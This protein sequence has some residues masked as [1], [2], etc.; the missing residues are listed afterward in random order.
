MKN[1]RLDG[2]HLDGGGLVVAVVC[3]GCFIAGMVAG[4]FMS[5][6]LL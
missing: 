6:T 3:L 1:A 2:R 5:V 4:G